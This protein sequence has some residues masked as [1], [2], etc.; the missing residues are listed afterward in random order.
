MKDTHQNIVPSRRSSR[1]RARTFP[2]LWLSA[3]PSFF[4]TLRCRTQIPTLL[5]GVMAAAQSAMAQA[6]VPTPITPGGPIGPP[7]QAVAGGTATVVSHFNPSQK[8]RLVIG[9]QSKDLPGQ[10]QLLKDLH[11]KNSPLFHQF[12]SA[13]EW[14]SKFSPSAQDEQAVVDWAQAQGLTVTS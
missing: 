10:E 2:C 1:R 12:L 6:P 5:L 7:P 8:L 14:N 11:D 4:R 13:A 9:L 3:S